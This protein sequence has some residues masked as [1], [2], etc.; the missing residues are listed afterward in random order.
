MVCYSLFIW[1]LSFDLF[2]LFDFLVSI[3]FTYKGKAFDVFDVS[4]Y[5][6]YVKYIMLY[7]PPMPKNVSYVFPGADISNFFK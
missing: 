1:I 4:F 7:I 5:S 3:F 6:L 2:L